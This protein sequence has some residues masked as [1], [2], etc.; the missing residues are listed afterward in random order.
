MCSVRLFKRSFALPLFWLGVMLVLSVV[1]LVL[2]LKRPQLGGRRAREHVRAE[3]PVSSS[4]SMELRDPAQTMPLDNERIALDTIQGMATHIW[5]L[6]LTGLRPV[7]VTVQTALHL[8]LSCRLRDAN[9]LSI[10]AGHMRAGLC[11]MEWTPT[12]T[13]PHS[14]EVSNLTRT[15]APYSITVER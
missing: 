9:G 8:E 3:S 6:R 2:L 11:S 13:G 1:G 7:R 14:V 15:D 5:P 10:A 4:D 12:R